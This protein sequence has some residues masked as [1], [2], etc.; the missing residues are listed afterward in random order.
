MVEQAEA[1]E[2]HHVMW[3]NR[4]ATKHRISPAGLEELLAVALSG[5]TSPADRLKR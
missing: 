4:N 2:G 3:L 5:G 1:S